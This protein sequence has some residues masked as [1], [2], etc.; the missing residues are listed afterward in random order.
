MQGICF[1]AFLLA[2]LSAA[3]F[4]HLFTRGTDSLRFIEWDSAVLV[5]GDSLVFELSGEKTVIFLKGR[6]QKNT[7]ACGK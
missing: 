5:S 6:K 2:C 3:T 1:T 4:L 7:A